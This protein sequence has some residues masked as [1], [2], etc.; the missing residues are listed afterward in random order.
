MSDNKEDNELEPGTV[1]YC[2]DGNSGKPQPG[3]RLKAV[4]PYISQMGSLTSKLRRQDRTARN[5]EG[6]RER[7]GS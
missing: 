3:D 4:R 1:M 7:M 5:G 2:D 6:R